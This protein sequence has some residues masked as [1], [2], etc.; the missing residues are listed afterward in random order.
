MKVD[1]TYRNTK[2]YICSRV[3]VIVAGGAGSSER[4]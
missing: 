4:Q 3:Q 2:Y 1:T